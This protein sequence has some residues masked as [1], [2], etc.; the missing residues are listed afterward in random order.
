MGALVDS[1]SNANFMKLPAESEAAS[2]CAIPSKEKTEGSK[3][4]S[5]GSKEKTVIK[6][7]GPKDINL[8]DLVANTPE[9]QSPIA[10]DAQVVTQSHTTF[11]ELSTSTPA[12]TVISRKKLGCEC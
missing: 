9:V 12:R 3:A 1:I 4:Q 2:S 10:V 7:K 8:D 6:S 11:P 5:K